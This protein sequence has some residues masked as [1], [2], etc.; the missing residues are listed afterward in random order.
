MVTQECTWLVQLLKD[1]H[2]PTNDPIMLRCDNLYAIQLAENPMFHARAKHV[3]VRYHFMQEKVLRGEI[4]MKY[5][6][7]E[8]QV[9]NVFTKALSCI[10]FDEF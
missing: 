7:I 3:E 5:T 1:L 9:A 10:K 6:Q 2:Q 4:N 8:D